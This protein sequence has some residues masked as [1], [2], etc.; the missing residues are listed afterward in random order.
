MALSRKRGLRVFPVVSWNRE[1]HACVCAFTCVSVGWFRDTNRPDD[2]LSFSS[3]SYEKY[4]VQ[5]RALLFSWYPKCSILGVLARAWFSCPFFCRCEF[6][7]R[8]KNVLNPE[9]HPAWR[10]SCNPEGSD[11]SLISVVTTL[12]KNSSLF[13]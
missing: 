8:E 9:Y 2:D 5:C 11:A 10:D 7:K 6:C 1:V 12:L 13:H 4:L 3:A